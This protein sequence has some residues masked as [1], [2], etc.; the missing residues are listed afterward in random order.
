[1]SQLTHCA[2]SSS[3]FAC[4]G[5][6]ECVSSLSSTGL[7]SSGG[8]SGGNRK[9]VV[10]DGATWKCIYL[11]SVQRIPGEAWG[12]TGIPSFPLEDRYPRPEMGSWRTPVLHSIGSDIYR[13]LNIC[14]REGWSDLRAVAE[15]SV[16]VRSND[17]LEMCL[18][19]IS[20]GKGE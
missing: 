12:R 8:L 10:E 1:M 14:L 7:D 4:P 20:F 17:G 5:P 13:H 3:L 18:L 16:G 11:T 9:W 2:T 6:G 19:R 15:R